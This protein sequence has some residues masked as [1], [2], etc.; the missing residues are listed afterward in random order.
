MKHKLTLLYCRY[1]TY[2]YN[3]VYYMSLYTYLEIKKGDTTVK[4]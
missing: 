2:F 4:F 3:C 1:N